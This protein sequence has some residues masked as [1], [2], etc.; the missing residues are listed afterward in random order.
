M[1]HRFSTRLFGSERLR[2]SPALP[3]RS[4]WILAFAVVSW[5]QPA[6]HALP[7]LTHADQI[8]RLTPEQA[9]LGYPVGFEASL[10]MTF[11]HRIFL[12]RIRLPAFMSKAAQS[13]GLFITGVNS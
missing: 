2:T 5:A 3:I 8:R 10:P 1:R 6:S 11:Q 4:F 13:Q 9:A 7:L 12:C